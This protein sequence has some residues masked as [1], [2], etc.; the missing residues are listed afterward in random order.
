[1]SPSTIDLDKRIESK[2]LLKGQELRTMSQRSLLNKVQKEGPV[3]VLIN[4]ELSIAMLP[5]NKFELL[6]EQLNE[7]E[8]FIED[9]QSQLE[10]VLLSLHTG[11]AVK[12]A[13]EGQSEEY[14]V[15]SLSDVMER[16][17]D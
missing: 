1:M 2:Q 16:I 4:S 3:G 13:E 14:K 12:R 11:D 7:K 9:L 10:D 5:W 17:T 8:Q 15:N 6:L